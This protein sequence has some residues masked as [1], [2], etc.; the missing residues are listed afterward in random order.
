MLP[1]SRSDACNGDIMLCC[2]YYHYSFMR[3]MISYV[4]SIRVYIMGLIVL[5]VYISCLLLEIDVYLRVSCCHVH[6][7]TVD[8][9]SSSRCPAD[10]RCPSA[11]PRP[12]HRDEGWHSMSVNSKYDI[13]VH[14]CNRRYQ[15]ISTCIDQ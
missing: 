5:I 4:H 3:L 8:M 14:A 1:K 10:S 11:R 2:Y 13:N 6:I 7:V 12:R 9:R 15:S